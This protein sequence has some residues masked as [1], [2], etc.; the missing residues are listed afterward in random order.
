MDSKRFHVEV[1]PE[2][3]EQGAKEYPNL[4]EKEAVALFKETL[5]SRPLQY[6]YGIWLR[7]KSV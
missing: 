4:T 6:P 5:H 7:V 1:R 3:R 2:S